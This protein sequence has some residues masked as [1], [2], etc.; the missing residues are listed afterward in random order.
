MKHPWSSQS[1]AAAARSA[2]RSVEIIAAAEAIAGAIKNV[3]PELPVIF[4]LHHLAHLVD[5]RS[6]DLQ[7]VA[8]RQEDAY[9]VFRVKKRGISGRHPAPVRKQR[10]ICVP[11]PFLM[12][13]QRWIAQ[14]ILNAIEPHAASFA[15]TPNR[16]L[17]GAAKKHV[18][19]KWLLKM[20]VRNF[21]E[22][23]SERDVYHVFRSLGYVALLSFQMARICTRLPDGRASGRED[24]HVFRDSSSLPY[25]P[26]SQGHLPQGAP[27]SPMLANLAMLSLDRRLS[28]LAKAEGFVYTRYADDL[29][30]SRRAQA[31]RSEVY[32][33]S[34]R[35]EAELEF[36]GLK[37][38]SQKTKISPPSARKVLLGVLVDDSRPRLT[39]SFRN[40]IETHLYAL[41]SE[42]I[43]ASAHQKKRGFASVI[44]MKRHIFG[45]ISFAHQVDPAYAST[46]Y[47]K[48]N[49]V[50]WTH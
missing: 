27:S 19:A 1:F 8:F 20:D 3:H 11:H 32:R 28:G 42:K 5:V 50:D 10:T 17:V 7:R 24:T 36:A 44:G 41:L 2:G 45:L 12:K 6:E 18:G 37:H 25:R 47:S 33:L 40:N 46:L 49:A 13:T 31:T 30:F 34:K 9:R 43:G 15:F 48:L 14:N 26:R 23:I 35:V 16:D 4:T 38:H 22:S 21:F 29:A 39:K